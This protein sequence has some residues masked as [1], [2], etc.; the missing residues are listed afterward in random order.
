MT[1]NG[2]ISLYEFNPGLFVS[3]YTKS[4]TLEG[5]DCEI[6]LQ[7]GEIEYFVYGYYNDGKIKTEKIK[8][9]FVINY[10]HNTFVLAENAIFVDNLNEREEDEDIEDEYEDIEDEYEEIEEEYEEL[11]EGDEEYIDIEYTYYR[12]ELS[13]NFVKEILKKNDDG[14]KE[15]DID[16]LFEYL[17]NK[18]VVLK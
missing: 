8:T 13:K 15:I 12:N 10:D 3:G 17:D 14:E 6:Y 11:E 4:K 1:V 7:D 9:Q 16:K 2:R 5:G 18:K